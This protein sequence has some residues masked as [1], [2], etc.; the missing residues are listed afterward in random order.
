MAGATSINNEI[1]DWSD[2]KIVVAGK[3]YKGITSIN[4]S[5]KTEK[6][7]QYG[8][9]SAPIGAGY[10]NQSYEVSFKMTRK[11]AAR[12]EA[13]A[14]GAG[15]DARSYTP[16]PII[17]VYRDKVDEGGIVGWTPEQTVTLNHVDITDISHPQDQGSQKLEVEYT[18]ICGEIL[19]SP[20][21]T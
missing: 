9:G 15:K 19:S 8:S 6:G 5:S 14:H 3:E 11:D 10:G 1:H 13:V 2:V 7:L 21:T 20:V 12:F 16:F 18:A 17:I 4:Y